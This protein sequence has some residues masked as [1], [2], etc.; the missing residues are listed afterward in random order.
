MERPIDVLNNAK[1]K[2]VLI[3]L[4]NGTEISGQLQAMDLHLNMWLESADQTFND[5][6]TK[7]GTVLVRGDNILYVSPEKSE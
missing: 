3:K 7:L 4:K 2:R 1:G 5:K 6:T